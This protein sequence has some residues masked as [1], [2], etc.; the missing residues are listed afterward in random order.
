VGDSSVVTCREH[1]PAPVGIPACGRSLQQHNQQVTPSIL[2]QM[3][4]RHS[5]KHQQLAQTCISS[6]SCTP[7]HR[8]APVLLKLFAEPCQWLL[9]NTT[10]MQVGGGEST[11]VCTKAG[12]TTSVMA[13]CQTATAPT[14]MHC[15]SHLHYMSP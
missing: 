2:Q 7:S 5:C 12:N 8:I 11:C 3:G 1:M 13:L 9:T 10:A 14:Q 15:S 4:L 6:L